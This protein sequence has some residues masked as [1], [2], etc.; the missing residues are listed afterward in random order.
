MRT[1][2]RSDDDRRY[3]DPRTAPGV[4]NLIADALREASTLASK[5]FELFRKEMSHNA[6]LLASGI[7]ALVV[8]AVFAIGTLILLTDALVDFI[9]VLVDSQALASLIV[10]GVTLV[11]MI[12]FLLIAWSRLSAATLEPRRTIKSIERDSEIVSQRMNG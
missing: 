2:E 6:K 7:F 12:V 10:A 8:A 5:E 3:D 11:L 1:G 4:Q 9:A